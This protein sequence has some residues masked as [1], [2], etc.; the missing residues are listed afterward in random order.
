MHTDT[1][2][3][4]CTWFTYVYLWGSLEVDEG[5]K[6]EGQGLEQEAVPVAVHTPLQV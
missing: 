2:L 3:C 4:T 5:I 1:H 6:L